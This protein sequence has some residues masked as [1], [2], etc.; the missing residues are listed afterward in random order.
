M[1]NCQLRVI[2]WDWV[3]QANAGLHST[4]TN[5]LAHSSGS[6]GWCGSCLAAVSLRNAPPAPNAACFQKRPSC[7]YTLPLNKARKCLTAPTLTCILVSN[8]SSIHSTGSAARDDC[9]S[10]FAT[11]SSDGTDVAVLYHGNEVHRSLERK[12]FSSAVGN[13]CP[14]LHKSANL[15]VAYY[16]SATAMVQPR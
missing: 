13:L 12:G 7:R 8:Q 4:R 14:G 3:S 2:P 16:L 11:A 5:T 15:A 9:P 10:C 1:F 6:C